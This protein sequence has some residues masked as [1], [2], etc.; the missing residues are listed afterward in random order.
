MFL[1]YT[2]TL[3][4]YTLSDVPSPYSHISQ[5]LLEFYPENH[6]QFHYPSPLWKNEQ[7]FIHLPFK[8]NEDINPTKASHPSM[9]PSDLLLAKQECSQL[10]EQGLIEPTDSDWACQAFYIE[11]RS[12]LVR[13][14]KRL[15]IDSQPLNSFLKDDKFPLPKVQTLF[16]HLQGART[17]SKFDLKAGFSPVDHPK[18]AFC[19]PNAHYQWTIMPFG[20][21]VTPSL[22]RKAMTKI[23]S[24]ILHHALVYIDD[25]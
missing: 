23:F 14:K 22:F 15:V 5:K 21:K 9:S 10:L 8:L 17:F 25:I 16:V 6:S 1:P 12:E 7:F 2:D 24:P 3:R 4:L 20:L 18:T 19:I 11:K 13:G